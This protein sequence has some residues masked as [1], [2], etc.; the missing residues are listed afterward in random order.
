MCLN[1]IRIKNPTRYFRDGI[2]KPTL[3]VP[4]GKCSECINAARMDWQIRLYYEHLATEELHDGFTFYFTLTYNG[5][6]P[7]IPLRDNKN[8]VIFCFDHKHIPLFIKR[9]RIQI[10]RDGVNLAIRHFIS[11]EYGDSPDVQYITDSGLRA[12]CTHRPHYHGLFFVSRLDGCPLSK[13]QAADYIR[14]LICDK[15]T[16]GDKSF[17]VGH[18]RYGFDLPAGVV[19]SAGPIGYCAK[20]LDKGLN[21]DEYYNSIISD[22]TYKDY[23]DDLKPKHYQSQGLGRDALS[24]VDAETLDS[25][26]IPCPVY[27]E[28]TGL[29]VTRNFRLPLYLMRK[30][31]YDFDK[32]HGVFV[33]SERGMRNLPNIMYNELEET[34]K[35]IDDFRTLYKHN[36]KRDSDFAAKTI[37]FLRNMYGNNYKFERIDDIVSSCSLLD[38]RAIANY[39]TFFRERSLDIFY[40]VGVIDQD[41][42]SKFSE[43]YSHVTIRQLLSLDYSVEDILCMPLGRDEYLNHARYMLKR[44]FVP[45]QVKDDKSPFFKSRVTYFVRLLDDY[46]SIYN[47]FGLATRYF[48]SLSRQERVDDY[49]QRRKV[50][51]R[52]FHKDKLSKTIKVS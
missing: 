23:L 48:A 18:D 39:I 17:T 28:A 43:D 11:S 45:S 36:F 37:E 50:L 27:D 7:S 34:A 33:P 25:G 14:Q 52:A 15:W 41:Y 6:C 44:T 35:S 46:I 40:K 47:C 5:V 1:P 22:E 8:R 13:V 38:S 51:K 3:L 32:D 20:Y 30:V 42:M 49:K 9:C 31:N 10:E 2:D 16:F 29:V 19:G 4:C 21:S 26:L 24:L 12:F